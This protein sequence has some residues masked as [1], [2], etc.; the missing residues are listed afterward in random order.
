MLEWLVGSVR[1]HGDMLAVS[2]RN[3]VDELDLAS[4]RLRQV[5]SRS[6]GSD[7]PGTPLS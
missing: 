5:V 7:E 3:A 1:R 4:A 2:V 6:M